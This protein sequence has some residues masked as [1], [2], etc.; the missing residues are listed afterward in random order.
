MEK[1][2]I[3]PDD[4]LAFM[5]VAACVVSYITYLFHEKKENIKLL[6][7]LNERY[8]DSE[9]IQIVV[10]YLREIDADT[11]VP[12]PYQTELFLRFFEELGLYMKKYKLPKEDVKNFFEFYLERLYTTERGKELLANIAHDEKEWELLNIYKEKTEFKY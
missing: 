8:L 12:R 7:Q 9:D 5:A 2:S 4:I 10:R 3:T 11:K 1:I 6:S